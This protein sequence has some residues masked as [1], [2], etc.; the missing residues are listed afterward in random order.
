VTLAANIIVLPLI[1]YSTGIFSLVSLPANVLILP[2]IPTAMFFGFMSGMTS[3]ISSILAFPF[4]FI[5]S[6]ILK[7]ILAVIHFF[8]SLP[9]ASVTIQKFPLFLMLLCYLFLAWYIFKKDK[10][11]IKI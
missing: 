8:A 6:L 11:K 3:F 5:G 1:L 10:S 4:G 7:Y 9:F 2:L